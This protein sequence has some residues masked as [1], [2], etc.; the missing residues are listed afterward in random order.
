MLLPLSQLVNI[1]FVIILL[2]ILLIRIQLSLRGRL[3]EM[4]KNRGELFELIRKKDIQYSRILQ[5]KQKKSG[6]YSNLLDK[7]PY[8]TSEMISQEDTRKLARVL[9]ETV[10]DLFEPTEVV[11]FTAIP[12]KKQLI[13]TEGHSIQLSK[14]GKH[15][16]YGKG[17]PGIV[18]EK[19]ITMTTRDFLNESTSVKRRIREEP[20]SECQMDILTPL[21]KDATLLGIIGMKRIGRDI[22]AEEKRVFRMIADMATNAFAFSYLLTRYKKMAHRDGLT[23]LVNRKSFMTL[24]AHHLM[25]ASIGYERFSI[26]MFDLDNFK[27]YN[28]QNGHLEGDSLLKTISRIVQENIRTHDIAARYGGEEFII[29]FPGLSGEKA[30]RVSEFLRKKIETH[31]FPHREEQPLGLISISGGIA[32]FPEDGN[33]VHDLISAADQRLYLAKNKGRNR[34]MLSTM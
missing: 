33:T 21:I 30:Y 23:G 13:L 27:A 25:Q 31:P 9:V 7:L 16:D 34:V 29:L 17:R 24:F 20:A 18:A 1:G 6:F 2:F 19:G 11:F 5:D 12:E 8:R 15:Y 4:E 32:G 3:K 10:V 14:F 22:R 28:D 26:F